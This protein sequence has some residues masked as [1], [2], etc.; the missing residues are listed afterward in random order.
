MSKRYHR[1]VAQ[2]LNNCW[3][4]RPDKLQTIL[5]LLEMRSAGIRLS[6]AEIQARIGNG[7]RSQGRS[8]DTTATGSKIAVLSL[9]GVI[10]PRMS[11]LEESSGGVSAESFG[12]AFDAAVNDPDVG[13]IVLDMNSPGGAAAGI[14]ELAAKIYAARNIKPVTAVGN[15]QICSACYWIAAAA[16]EIVLTPSGEAGSIGVVIVHQD[17]SQLNERLGIKSTII[18]TAP[19][20]FI[21]NHLEPL[22]EEG[23]RFLEGRAK[24]IHT[25]FVA[26]VAEYRGVSVSKVESDFGQGASLA[27]SDALAAGLVDRIA[28]LDQVLAELTGSA[29]APGAVAAR[30]AALS[31]STEGTSMNPELKAL[32]V[33]LGL[34]AADAN[35]AACRIAL[36][37][38]FA[39]RGQAVPATEALVLAA[40]QAATA[41]PLLQ[42]TVVTTPTAAAAVSPVAGAPTAAAGMAVEDIMAA[43]QLAPLSA[44]A[45][46]NLS[47]DLIRNRATLTTS[48]VLDRI[49]RESATAN[50]PAGATRIAV[51]ADS[52]DKFHAAAR[53]AVLLRSWGAVNVQAPTQIYDYRQQ[54]MVA[55]QP[56]A[57]Q[58]YHLQSIPRLIEQCLMQAGVPYSQVSRLSRHQLANLALG[59]DPSQCGVFASDG[60]SFNVSG[61]FANI[62]YD[63]S[64]VMLRKSYSEVNTTFQAWMKQAASLTDFKLVH[65]VIAGELSDPKA[66]PEDGEFEETTMTDGKES[67]KLTVW[68]HRWSMT[69]QMMVDDDLNSFADTQVKHF[70]AMRRKQ[71]KLA[72]GVL[73]D[74]A[75]LADGGA[76]FNSTALTSTG[77]HNNLATGAGAPSVATLNTLAAKMAVMTGLNVSEQTTLNIEPAF[78]LAG[79]LLKGT[80]LELLGSVTNPASTNA[81][82]KNIWENGLTP[83][84][85]AQLGL[86]GGGTD[87]Q[88]FL[89]ANAQDVDTVEYAY[90]QGLEAP[91]FDQQV[92]FDRLAMSQRCY[93]AFAVKALDFRGLQKHAGA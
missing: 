78:I 4:I 10:A 37:A 5:Q 61:M 65:K 56:A 25:N 66:I 88:W 63:A 2:I 24:A 50:P 53:D 15:L 32:L 18:T 8:V 28:T 9:F 72:Y 6:P 92:S 71:N 76:L 7:P 75:T 30:P 42:P 62:F 38:Y 48:Q 81:N 29:S 87:T 19:N 44:E 79:P 93:Q 67:Y 43:C 58:S 84:F 91:A 59:Q 22:S 41:A 64:N 60:P 90:L 45:R 55:W 47:Q 14:P 33:K 52:R 86:A 26:A 40:I 89:A 70:R 82:V 51:T 54:A 74:N 73:K 49:N 1:I 20:K 77:G 34:C 80:I 17:E 23:R 3:A 39:G 11:S 35:D 13:H 36:N 16:R 85:D 21:A 83:V 12:R 46:F 31:I 69:W 68:G 57:Q 27:A